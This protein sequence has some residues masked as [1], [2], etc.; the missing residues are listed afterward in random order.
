MPKTLN[1]K[2]TEGTSAKVS[3]DEPNFTKAGAYLEASIALDAP[4]GKN[5][6]DILDGKHFSQEQLAVE[7]TVPPA[8]DG[9]ETKTMRVYREVSYEHLPKTVSVTIH[10]EA[11]EPW[12]DDAAKRKVIEDANSV[13]SQ[14]TKVAEWLDKSDNKG[15]E[16]SKKDDNNGGGRPDRDNSY[17]GRGGPRG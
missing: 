13:L 7:I 3:K 12:P 16:E 11:T 5:I 8:E 2:W 14:V 15:K 1:A 4:L 17:R 10:Y 9:G 6:A